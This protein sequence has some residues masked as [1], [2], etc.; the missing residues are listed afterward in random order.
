MK[1]LKN[2]FYSA[3]TIIS[4]STPSLNASGLRWDEEGIPHKGWKPVE[5]V[6][7][8][9]RDGNCEF[10]GNHIKYEHHLSHEEQDLQMIAGSQCAIKLAEEYKTTIESRQRA[11]ISAV[12]K[13]T[14]ARNKWI[15]EGWRVKDNG[16]QGK[17]LSYN[18]WVNIFRDRNSGN[19]KYVH[20]DVFSDAFSTIEDAKL[21]FYRNY[22]NS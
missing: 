15:R 20:R 22:F 6:T 5:I 1:T 8:E 17:R 7:R 10:C 21:A 19:W 18:N 9:E 14:R 2:I 16:N 4:I 12:R 3:I 11:A 13:A